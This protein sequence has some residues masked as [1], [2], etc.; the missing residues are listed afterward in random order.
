MPGSALHAALPES[1]IVVVANAGHMPNLD[2]PD[3]YNRIVSEFARRHLP[4]AA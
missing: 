4:V 3:D 2:A 1:E